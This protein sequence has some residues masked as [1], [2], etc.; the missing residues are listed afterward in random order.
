M[1]VVVPAVAGKAVVV[2]VEV[3]KAVG[4][5]ARAP[6][7]AVGLVGEVEVLRAEVMEAEVRVVVSVAEEATALAA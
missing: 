1:V 5:T 3:A 6:T 4:A 2:Q 7:V